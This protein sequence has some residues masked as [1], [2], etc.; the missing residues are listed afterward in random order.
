MD[1]FIVLINLEKLAEPQNLGTEKRDFMHAYPFFWVASVVASNCNA[2]YW[3]VLSF[4]SC[5]SL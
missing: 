1:I 3:H 2:S 4:N 5:F